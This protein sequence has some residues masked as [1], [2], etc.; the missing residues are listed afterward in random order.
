MRRVKIRLLSPVY[1][2]FHS[3]NFGEEDAFSPCEM[4]SS[5]E[6]NRQNAS[7]KSVFAFF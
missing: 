1:H 5:T 6:A 7:S 2:F 3:F 4:H